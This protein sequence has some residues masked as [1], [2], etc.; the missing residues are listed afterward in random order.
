MREKQ[1]SI[2]RL[3]KPSTLAASG[4]PESLPTQTTG[5]E[6]A[7]PGSESSHLLCPRLQ[8]SSLDPPPSP[9]ATLQSPNPPP[10]GSVQDRANGQRLQSDL[11]IPDTQNQADS[12]RYT[13]EVPV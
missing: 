13:S 7:V 11:A 4:T 6:V 8:S 2:L 1:G 9:L 12:V 3:F 5:R 10:S